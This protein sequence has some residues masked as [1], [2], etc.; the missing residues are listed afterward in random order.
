MDG[1]IEHERRIKAHAG[2]VWIHKFAD[3]IDSQVL[4]VDTAVDLHD[5][6]ELFRL[7]N[8]LPHPG[9]DEVGI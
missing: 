5:L 8:N 2:I 4:P 6:V 7:E 3:W 9:D 1:R